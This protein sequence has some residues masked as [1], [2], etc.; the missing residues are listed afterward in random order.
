LLFNDGSPVP[1]G[2]LAQT[3]AE[4][5]ARF[6]AA[7]WETQLVHGSWEHEG[8]TFRDNLTRFFVDVPTCRNIELFQGVQANAKTAVQ[9]G[10]RLDHLTFRGR[11]LNHRDFTVCSAFLPSVTAAGAPPMNSVSLHCGGWH[12]PRR[13]PWLRFDLESSFCRI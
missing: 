11:N 8:A 10:G 7:S 5:R 12:A 1:E 6:G 9:A 4:L 2:L 13:W 3:F